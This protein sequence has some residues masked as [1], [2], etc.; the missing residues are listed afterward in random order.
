VFGAD[1]ML[2]DGSGT[3][4]RNFVTQPSPS[5]SSNNPLKLIFSTIILIVFHSTPTCTLFS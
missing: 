1:K 2:T 3:I 4:P 5:T